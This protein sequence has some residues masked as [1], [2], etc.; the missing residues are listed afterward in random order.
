MFNLHLHICLHIMRNKLYTLSVRKLRSNT[1][2]VFKLNRNVFMRLLTCWMSGMQKYIIQHVESISR[3][4]CRRLCRSE[5]DMQL[6]P[7]WI[8]YVIGNR[9]SHFFDVDH[10]RPVHHDRSELRNLYSY[11]LRELRAT[12]CDVHFVSLFLDTDATATADSLRVYM[13]FIYLSIL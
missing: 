5:I 4:I 11:E 9:P 6:V 2:R 10:L 8:L 13:H 7:N 1:Y 12:L 3:H